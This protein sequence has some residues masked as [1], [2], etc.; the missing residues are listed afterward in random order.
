MAKV[1]QVELLVDVAEGGRDLE[2][3]KAAADEFGLDKKS[4]SYPR[5]KVTSTPRGRTEFVKGLVVSMTEPDALKWVKRGI[6][7]IVG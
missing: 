5:L 2:K 1:V 3:A 4:A 7:T 6:G